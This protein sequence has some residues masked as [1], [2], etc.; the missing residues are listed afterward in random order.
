MGRQGVSRRNFMKLASAVSAGLA[1]DW[2]GLEALAKGIGS[3][4]EFP[5]TVIGAGLG[6]LSAAAVLARQ[7]FPVTLLEQHDR[8]GGY[9]TSFDRAAGKYTFEV[10]LHATGTARGGLMKDA[11][12]KAG[13]LDRAKTVEMPEL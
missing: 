1:F 10:S 9:A 2:D 7:G 11:L 13:V 5:V 3:K 6:G 12:D 4:A 8:P